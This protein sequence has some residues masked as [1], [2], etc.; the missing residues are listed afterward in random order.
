MAVKLKT[1]CRRIRF[2]FG[3][4]NQCTGRILDAKE[5]LFDTLDALKDTLRGSLNA[6]KPL[7]GTVAAQVRAQ[8]ARHLSRLG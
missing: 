3:I 4:R 6:R 2:E 5:P 1:A 8:M 7:G